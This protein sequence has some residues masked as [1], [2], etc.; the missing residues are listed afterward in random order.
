MHTR[1][2]RMFGTLVAVSLVL[3]ACDPQDLM[4]LLDPQPVAQEA[5]AAE[6]DATDDAGETAKTVEADAGEAK[7]EREAEHRTKRRQRRAS[8]DTTADTVPTPKKTKKR[9]G[10]GGGDGDAS[11]GGGSA[12]L[13]SVEQAIHDRLTSTRRSA[14]LRALTLSAEI[15]K[16]A[17]S[18]S[19][20]MAQS[21]NFR[22][23]DLGSAGV[24][25]ENIAWGQQGEAAVHDAWMSSTG[26]RDNRMSARW[27]EYGV[28]VCND[29][30]GRPYYT[31]RF[32]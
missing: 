8:Q 3:T 11:A 5:P 24:S 19:C 2:I 22:H 13:S 27:S 21:G 12:D 26:H 20:Q 23:A 14:G 30:N 16:G 10:G 7:E 29:S 15:S 1:S 17:K 28:G 31:E 6:A 32:R 18:W 25:G 9:S 4:Q